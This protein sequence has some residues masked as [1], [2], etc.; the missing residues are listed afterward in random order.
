MGDVGLLIDEIGGRTIVE[1]GTGLHGPMSGDSMLVWI[2]TAADRIIAIDMDQNRLDEVNRAVGNHPT[3]ELVLA[4]GIEFVAAFS[5]RIDLLYL[6]F[7]TPDSGGEFPGTGRADAY[8]R[9]Y[10]AALP[11][12]NDRS[13]ILI[14]DTDHV[15]PW[16]QSSIVPAARADGFQVRWIGRQT[17]L[18]RQGPE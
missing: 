1:I 5:G 11:K 10:R 14:D 2:E 9:A 4:D 17:C 12:M 7:W 15:D 3:V 18:E 6:D 8:F 13:I 16:K